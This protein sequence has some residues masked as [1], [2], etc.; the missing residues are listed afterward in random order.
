MADEHTPANRA[1]G[2]GKRPRPFERLAGGLH[3]GSAHAQGETSL[4]VTALALPG[5]PPVYDAQRVRTPSQSA[6]RLLQLIEEPDL[7]AGVRRAREDR[8]AR[9]E[10]AGSHRE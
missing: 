5:P 7:L 8:T 9:P 10:E 1:P 6:A 2:A 3:E 4:R